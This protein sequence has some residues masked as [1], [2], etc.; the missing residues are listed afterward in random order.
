MAEDYGLVK[1][2]P[3]LSSAAEAFPVLPLYVSRVV[4]VVVNQLRLRRDVAVT[5]KRNSVKTDARIA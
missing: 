5:E 1:N 3:A 2:L 4:S